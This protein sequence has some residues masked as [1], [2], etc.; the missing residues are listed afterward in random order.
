MARPL[1]FVELVKLPFPYHHLLGKLTRLP[2]LGRVVDHMLFDGDDTL[3]LPADRL[4]QVGESIELPGEMVLPSQIVEHFIEQADRHWIM[5]ECLC[6]DASKCEKYPIDHGCLFLGDATMGINPRLGRLVTKE[7]AL[8]HAQ[9]GREAGLMHMVGRNKLDT[10]WLGVGPGERLMTICNCC[11]CCC[12]WRVLP[13]VT[14]RI[15]DKV[16]GMPGVSVRVSDKCQGRG[17]CIQGICFVD[18]I[19]LD[20]DRAVISDACRGCGLC[21]DVC[22]EGAIELTIEDDGFVKESIDRLSAAVNVT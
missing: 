4:I 18:A 5:N 6:R 14:P 9:R 16:T 19:H 1:W 10:L 2:V 7:E 3:Y 22:P 8:A 12:V 20:G 11:P 13:H 15:G 17:A 21:V